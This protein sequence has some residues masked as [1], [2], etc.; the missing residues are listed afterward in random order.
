M[1][2]HIPIK[3]IS[4]KQP[5]TVH[6]GE[7]DDGCYFMDW[8]NHDGAEMEEVTSNP[9]TDYEYTENLLVCDKCPAQYIGDEWIN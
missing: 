2:I 8:C 1:P 6:G 4:T 3:Q 9:G 5:I 7:L